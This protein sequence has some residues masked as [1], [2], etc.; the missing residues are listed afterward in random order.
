MKVYHIKDYPINTYVI[1]DSYQKALEIYHQ[2]D[3]K[4]PGSVTC[5]GPFRLDPKYDLVLKDGKEHKAAT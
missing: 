2:V 5:L 3:P 4:E 1:T